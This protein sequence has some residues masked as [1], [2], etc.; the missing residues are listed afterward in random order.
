[1][2][3]VSHA[4]DQVIRFC[5]EA[6]W[7]D[8]GQIV[9]RGA[10][11]EVVKAYEKFIRQLDDQR[12]RAKNLKVSS[13]RFDAFTRD[14]YTDHFI[15]EVEADGAAAVDVAQLTL[16]RDGEAEDEVA[17]GAPQDADAT[18][19][20][21]VL[22]T[23]GW[24]APEPGDPTPYRSVPTGGAAQALFHLWFLYTASAYE[25]EVSYRAPVGARVRV[26][27]GGETLGERELPAAAE[28]ATAR[29][30][31]T[32]SD[33]AV[34]AEAS[35]E[36]ASSISISRWPGEGTFLIDSVRLLDDIG[37]TQAV[38]E[39]RSRLVIAIRAAANASGRFPVQPAATL[40]RTD[41]VLVTN[42]VGPSF[43][44]DAVEG[45]YVDFRLDYGALNL[46]DGRYTISIALYRTLS[47]TEA[48]EA[49]DL[50]DR[51]YEFEVQGNA[52]FDNGIFRH[53][54]TWNVE[55]VGPVRQ[56]AETTAT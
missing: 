50:L 31:A 23:T 6:I 2:L 17:V 16:L 22:P 36:A 15:V 14:T 38:F 4:L 45:G 51:S 9:M 33:A 1:V 24:S 30:R 44:V 12:L 19:S 28:W 29:V 8:R 52:P 5:D 43:E 35:A 27:R 49:Y 41:G 37:R 55:V 32:V 11:T 13:G 10:T 18:Q 3:L 56:E 26:V 46:G 20:A 25:V 34:D 54:P 42:L 7:L 48:T 47:Q 39:A 40:Y 53:A 21:S